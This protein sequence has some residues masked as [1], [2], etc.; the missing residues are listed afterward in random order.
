MI[1]EIQLLATGVSILSKV[2]LIRMLVMM[3]MV[4]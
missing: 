4:I 1:N 3:M 2:L